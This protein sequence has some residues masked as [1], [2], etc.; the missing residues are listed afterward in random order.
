MIKVIEAL[1]EGGVKYNNSLND[2]KLQLKN[3]NCI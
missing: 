1:D 2:E 3:C